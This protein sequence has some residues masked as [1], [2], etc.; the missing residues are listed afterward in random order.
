M[1]ISLAGI[2][3]VQG[4]WI[5]DTIQSN[6]EHF[7]FNANESLG[8]VAKKINE[9]EFIRYFYP[10]KHAIDSI[11]TNKKNY[12]EACLIK[13]VNS[14]LNNE[15]KKVKAPLTKEIKAVM[16]S[17]ANSLAAN[18]KL[19]WRHHIGAKERLDQL[20][21]TASYEYFLYQ[22]LI[23]EY[24][25]K[26]PINKRVQKS[27]IN[28]FLT[29]ELEK[30]G[31]KV[32]FEFSIYENETSTIVKSEN[33]YIASQGMYR[34]PIFE[35][36][37]GKTN[38]YLVVNF[39]GKNSFVW[40]SILSMVLLSSLLVLVILGTYFYAYKQII[41][42]RKI[43]EIKTDFI[44]NMTHE[45]KTPIATIN[46]ALDFMKNEKVADD[47]DMRKRYLQMIRFENDRI[48]DQV[49]SVLRISHLEHNELLINKGAINFHEIIEKAITHVKLNVDKEKG[50]IK[51]HLNASKKSI[52]ASDEH[53]TNVIVNVLDNAVKYTNDSPK[54]DIFTEN[55]KN[56]II[57][58]VAD[59][60]IGMS[61][62]CREKVFDNFFRMP[63][64][65]VH[66]VKGYG[67]G[68]SYAKKIIEDHQGKI[69]VKSSKGKGTTL[70][71]QLPL[72]TS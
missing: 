55:T 62:Y 60:G 50:Y 33:F 15:T 29:R 30:R 53:I 59:Q 18:N 46:L 20:A 11:K 69:L 44:N 68:L 48:H 10:L 52:F 5:S 56:S 41:N 24:T 31:V 7:S 6:E 70:I 43:S 54:I 71:I 72:I 36:D 14:E 66:N 9:R 57:L 42:Q 32:N 63:T 23:K 19:Y 16:D 1:T 67:L 65:D 61:K 35:D 3:C 17:I 2:I 28:Q 8:I 47:S 45:L 4:Y 27:E 21:T 12:N 49:E 51:T 22:N 64:G 58:K 39:L 38:L 13:S 40:S 26:I 37:E 34:T 25:S